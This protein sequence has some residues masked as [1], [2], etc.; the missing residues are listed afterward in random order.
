VALAEG[1]LNEPIERIILRLA[2]TLAYHAEVTVGGSA[3]AAPPQAALA[4][5]TS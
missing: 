5:D 2:E 1:L 4:A 3:P